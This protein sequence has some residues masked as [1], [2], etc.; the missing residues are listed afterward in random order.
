MTY[1]LQHWLVTVEYLPGPDNTM[2]DALSREERC[3]R[4]SPEDLTNPDASLV[5]GDVE[6]GA[7]HKKEN[8][9]GV[10]TPT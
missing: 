9:V 10:T 6:A 5:A 2:A 1:K 4:M 8:S 3:R 7:S